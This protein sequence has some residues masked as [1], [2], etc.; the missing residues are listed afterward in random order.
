MRVFF[1]L[2]IMFSSILKAFAQDTDFASDRPGLSDDPALIKKNTWQIATGFD[3]S[4]YNHYQVW[5]PSTSTLKYAISNRLEA[6]MDF[7]LQYDNIQKI[8]GAVAPSFGL[9]TKISDQKK[10][11]P[12]FC[13]YH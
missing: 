6:R 13:F 9:K 4:N 1:V 5:L 12:Y 7:G 11:N 10:R 2:I 8:F 3:V